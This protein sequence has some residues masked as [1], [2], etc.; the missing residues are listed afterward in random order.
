MQYLI[1]HNEVKGS[2]EAGTN[3]QFWYFSHTYGIDEEAAVLYQF[4]ADEYEMYDKIAK[5]L[6]ATRLDEEVNALVIA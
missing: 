5:K 2:I 4:S 1:W 3:D 6:Q